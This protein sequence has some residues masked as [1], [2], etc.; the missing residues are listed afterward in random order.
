M[1]NSSSP[2]SADLQAGASRSQI[3]NPKPTPHDHQG[4][5]AEAQTKAGAQGCVFPRL[6]RCGHTGLLCAQTHSS[7]RKAVSNLN[8]Q[9]PDSAVQSESLL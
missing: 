2:T 9:Q 1:S 8:G 3:L 4:S 5:T 7:G 6:A